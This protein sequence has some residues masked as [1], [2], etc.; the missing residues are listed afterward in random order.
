M[1]FFAQNIDANVKVDANA[2][3]RM[4]E[5]EK[6]LSLV[7]NFLNWFTNNNNIVNKICFLI[8]KDLIDNRREAQSNILEFYA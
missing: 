4:F 3:N 7:G 1:T 8:Y 5:L 6:R 2:I